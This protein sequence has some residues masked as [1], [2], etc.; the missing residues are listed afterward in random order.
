[1]PRQATAARWLRK[2]HIMNVALQRVGRRRARW[3]NAVLLCGAAVLSAAACG[4]PAG[5]S[6]RDQANAAPKMITWSHYFASN[7]SR[8]AALVATMRLA[9]KATGV[10][11]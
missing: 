9:E 4:L 6:G 7:D 10:E 8:T 11:I 1:M 5:G 3:P 2:A